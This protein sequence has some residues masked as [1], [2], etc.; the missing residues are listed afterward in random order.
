MALN[1]YSFEE[2]LKFK[3][4][5]RLSETGRER[6]TKME[7]Q[8]WQENTRDGELEGG[9]TDTDRQRD[10]DKDT[11]REKPHYRGNLGGKGM[12]FQNRRGPPRSQDKGISGVTEPYVVVLAG[13]WSFSWLTRKEPTGTK[14]SPSLCNV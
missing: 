11:E 13:L 5:E 9:Q 3:R 10:R 12:G 6:W 7:R 1:R 4:R 14:A 8:R 2:A